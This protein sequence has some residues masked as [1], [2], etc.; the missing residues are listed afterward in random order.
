M[1]P[2][3]CRTNSFLENYNGY[4]TRKL[5]KHIETNWVNFMN[6]IK[7]ESSRIIYKLYNATANNIKN[8]NIKELTAIVNPFILSS[9]NKV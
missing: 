2:S 3:D 9:I 5:G 8:L 4:I 6:F 1:I 7:D